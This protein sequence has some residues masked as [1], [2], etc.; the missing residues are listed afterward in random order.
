MPAR[1]VQAR[2]VVAD[3]GFQFQAR[4]QR[5]RRVHHHQIHSAG[6]HQRARDFQALLRGCRLGEGHT[7][8]VDA[9]P[10]GIGGIEGMVG[11]DPRGGESVLLDVGDALYG[12]RGFPAARRS[13]EFDHVAAR[14]SAAQRLIE[15]AEAR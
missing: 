4:N 11:I 13:E 14:K 9:Q 2:S 12:K 7:L 10:R 5:R 15:R 6:A 1:G 3:A 8:H